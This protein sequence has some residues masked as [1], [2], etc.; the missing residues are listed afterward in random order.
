MY[1]S[2]NFVGR[3]QLAAAEGAA[4]SAEKRYEENRNTL[5]HTNSLTRSPLT[6]S[7]FSF[8]HPPPPSLP[9]LYFSF[10]FFTPLLP[11][12]PLPSTAG[13]LRPRLSTGARWL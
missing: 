9:S 12:L 5:K 4:L 11:P 7:L 6:S 13:M 2:F 10:F 1:P 8:P 3:Y